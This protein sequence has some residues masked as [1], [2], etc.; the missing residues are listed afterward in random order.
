MNMSDTCVCTYVH[1]WVYKYTIVHENLYTC[2]YMCIYIYTRVD[3]NREG[4]GGMV[5]LQFLLHVAPPS[6]RLPQGQ[7]R[8]L[9][10]LGFLAPNPA[11][12]LNDTRLGLVT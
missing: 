1:V 11:R 4:E 2:M 10:V 8:E 12:R 7:G 6:D 5:S 9:H 3:I